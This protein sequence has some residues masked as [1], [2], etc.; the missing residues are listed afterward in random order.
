MGIVL[1]SSQNNRPEGKA[2]LDNGGAGGYEPSSSALAT[3]LPAKMLAQ[4][5]K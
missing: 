1:S 2:L 3:F 4:T 5:A